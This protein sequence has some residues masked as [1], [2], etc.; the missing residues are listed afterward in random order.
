MRILTIPKTNFTGVVQMVLNSQQ[1]VF[2]EIF[3][4]I[5]FTLKHDGFAQC[6]G[7]KHITLQSFIIGFEL[8]H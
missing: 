8:H 2:S 5:Y 6:G 4:H 7:A 1:Q 3:R